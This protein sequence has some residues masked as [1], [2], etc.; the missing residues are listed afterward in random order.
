MV[1]ISS[2]PCT[3]SCNLSSKG[4]MLV[5]HDLRII[6]GEAVK[7]T[8][9]LVIFPRRIDSADLTFDDIKMSLDLLKHR[10]VWLFLEEDARRAASPGCGPLNVHS[11]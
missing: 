5:P 1:D 6:C 2:P 3:Q 8:S 10:S 11:D 9:E 4:T 7:L